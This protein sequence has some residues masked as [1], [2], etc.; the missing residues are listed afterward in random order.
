MAGLIG[1]RCSE[2]IALK[3]WNKRLE[4][5][6]QIRHRRYKTKRRFFE[7]MAETARANI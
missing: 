4:I 6:D 5:I 2:I 7:N 3:D 1:Q